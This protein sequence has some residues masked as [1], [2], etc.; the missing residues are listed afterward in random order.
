MTT[1]HIWITK[2]CYLFHLQKVT[3]SRTVLSQLQSFPSMRKTPHTQPPQTEI[4][5]TLL[6]YVLRAKSNCS[7]YIP[8]NG[9]SLHS[10]S[11][12]MKKSS[13]W[14]LGPLLALQPVRGWKFHSSA[15][16]QRQNK[17]QTQ[18]LFEYIWMSINHCRNLIARSLGNIDDV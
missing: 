1:L 3:C 18:V 10:L 9:C 5:A 13:L 2:T 12:W 14:S 8:K 16:Q 15:C 11:I 17:Q 4:P 6:L 7:N